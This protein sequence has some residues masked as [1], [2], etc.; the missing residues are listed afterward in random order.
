MPERPRYQKATHTGIKKI[1]PQS[2]SVSICKGP[3]KAHA[4]VVV[5]HEYSKSRTCSSVVCGV[6]LKS[7]VDPK[8]VYA[9]LADCG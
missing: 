8:I 7:V 2:L 3:K 9:S 4:D 1:C 6:V 5:V